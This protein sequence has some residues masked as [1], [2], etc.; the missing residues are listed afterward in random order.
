MRAAP[1]PRPHVVRSTG[2]SKPTVSE[3]LGQ[4]VDLGLLRGSDE[5]AGSRGRVRSCMT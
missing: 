1:W 2:L 3:V 5:P 4:L